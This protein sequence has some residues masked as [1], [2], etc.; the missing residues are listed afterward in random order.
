MSIFD[1]YRHEEAT[2]LEPGVHRVA[3]TEV[4]EAISKS[5]G[6]PMLVITMQPS[7]SKIEIRHYIVKN[8][9]FNRNMTGFYDCFGIEEGDTDM[10]GW[11]GAVGAAQ[12]VEDENGYLKIRRLIRRDRQGTLPPWEGELPVRQSVTDEFVQADDDDDLPF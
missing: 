9:Y 1:G 2:V 5:S 3:V 8:E 10:I 4:E 6:S 7:G 11:V 12:I